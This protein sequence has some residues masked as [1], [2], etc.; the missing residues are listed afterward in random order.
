M[1]STDETRDLA[2]RLQHALGDDYVV[3]RALGAG[4]FAVVFLVRD[5]KLKRQLAV[6]V[7]SPDAITSRSALE[8][9]RREAETVAQL[10]HPNI[11]PLHFIGQKD[12]L[13][14]LTMQ[15]VDGGSL[16]DR[17][18]REG[19][20]PIDD[21]TRILREVAGALAHAHKRGV[22]HRD[23]KPQNI[24]LDAETGRALV[25]DFGIARTA[26]AGPLTG[27]GVIIGTPAYL[28]PEQLTGE[29]SD[30]RADIYALGIMAYEML[31][32]T[33]PFVGT[34]PTDAMFKRLVNTPEPIVATRP[35]APLELCRVI[36]RC[37]VREPAGRFQSAAEIVAALDG[38]LVGSGSTGT[39]ARGV[40]RDVPRRL[41]ATVLMAGGLI[42]T[43]VLG[44]AVMLV[45]RG[46]APNGPP[47][48]AVDAGMAALP[49]G[50]YPIGA[51][52]GPV[53]SRPAHGV[54]LAPF[55]LDQHEVT[56][57]EYRTFVDAGRAA[58][59]WRAR[60]AVNLPVTAV[61]Y[62]EAA[63]YCAWKHPDGG[64]LPSEEEWEAA[65][66]GRDGRQYPW[67]ETWDPAAANTMGAKRG[68]PVAVGSFPR[69]R[70]PEG[71][72]DLIGNVWEWTS[73]R[74]HS[75]PGAPPVADSSADFYVIRGGAH[76]TIDSV[77]TAVFRARAGTGASRGD[78]VNTGFRCAMAVRD[79]TAKP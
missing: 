73:S 18:E 36:E 39:G 25:S 71:V 35:D 40:G 70:T 37:L 28:S 60:P 29:G 6:K 2:E 72:N 74:W 44:G 7:L 49:G 26:E 42:V 67:G 51:D 1:P 61:T 62:S 63:N 64:R 57:G 47:R 5:V 48:G 55:G 43:A 15:C 22:I 50:A 54:P 30:H 69:G 79:S 17:L 76:N 46:R 21:A 31:A 14:Y 19:R 11:V 12:D 23:I 3:D 27:T 20:L 68:R 16:G 66:R 52:R 24:L 10:S 45:L 13:V 58:A 65:A 33:L 32:G 56:V 41:R 9:F 38:Q 34:T 78:L 75:Y 59:P 8:R 53:S 4:G 77:A